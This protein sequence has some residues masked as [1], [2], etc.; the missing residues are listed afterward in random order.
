MFGMC[1]SISRLYSSESIDRFGGNFSKSY[2]A[3]RDL[4]GIYLDYEI[5]KKDDFP[6][7]NNDISK[8]FN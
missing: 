4:A 2:Y 1:S 8:S 3:D 7:V 5:E 6:L